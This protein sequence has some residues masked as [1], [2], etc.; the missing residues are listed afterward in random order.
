MNLEEIG[1]GGIDQIDL[2]Q[3]KDPMEGICENGNKPS[4]SIK[5][6]EFLEWLHK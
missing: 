2:D 5:C 1:W 6:E 3:D 4:G